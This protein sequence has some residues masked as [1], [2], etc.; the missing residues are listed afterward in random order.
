MNLWNSLRKELLE[1]GVKRFLGGHH[2]AGDI[3]VHVTPAGEIRMRE[4]FASIPGRRDVLGHDSQLMDAI[5]QYIK[6][7]E[8]FGVH[9]PG[10]G[11]T[12][13]YGAVCSPSRCR[14]VV[15]SCPSSWVCRSCC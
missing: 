3:L 14:A 5:A 1:A 11:G 4:L 12:M 9:G 8:Q 15:S 13:R 6:N 2:P 10:C 7:V